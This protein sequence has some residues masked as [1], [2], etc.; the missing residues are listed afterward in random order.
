MDCWLRLS[1]VQR[2]QLFQHLF[3]DDGFE[4]V[5][6][7]L[8]GRWQSA[9]RTALTAAEVFPIPYEACCVREPDL[10]TW[11]TEAMLPALERALSKK[12][13]VVKVHSHPT[14]YERFSALDDESDRRLFPSLYGWV[15]SVSLHASAVML[16]DG[17]MFGRTVGDDGEFGELNRISVAGDD[18]MLWGT[19]SAGRLDGFM[20]K[21]AQSFGAG[22]AALLQRLSAGVVGCS[23]TGSPVIEQL[24]RLGIGR[25]VL[26]DP[27]VVEEKN[28]N[29]ILHATIE[30]AESRRPKVE[31]Q[32]EAV[33][34]IGLGTKVDAFPRSLDDREVVH[35]LAGCDVLFGC[36]DSI[37]GRHLLNRIA[38]FYVLPYFDLGVRL[39]ADGLGSVSHVCGTVHYL[40]PGGSSLLSRG[41]YTLE[42]LQAA[43]LR[44]TN[45]DEYKARLREGYIA[46]VEE[47]RPAVISVN[48]QIASLAVNEFLARLHP[49][50]QFDNAD[51][52][53]HR[54]SLEQGAFF[55]EPQG[56]PC[57]ILSRHLG[58]GDVSPLLEMPSLSGN[59]KQR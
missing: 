37:D 50:R 35:A 2:G 13:S 31:V 4:A 52:A 10:V 15:D 36:M 57:K 43:S 56:E 55:R 30:D 6:L 39:V 38:T 20:A 34:Q 5:A 32:R 33:E 24:V 22:T 44:R 8:C 17:R 47:D 45:P 54:L 12:L 21:N 28:L 11:K 16:P 42:Q 18:L 3:P 23:G 7:V 41:L 9:E 27:D 46:G 29:R 58:R 25:L 48:M 51:F 49:Y 53:V 19:G 59:G 1:G 26:V 14:G 40:E